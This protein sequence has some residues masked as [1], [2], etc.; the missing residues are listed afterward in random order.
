MTF[1]QAYRLTLGLNILVLIFYC[2]RFMPFCEMIGGDKYGYAVIIIL[3]FLIVLYTLTIV[4]VLNIFKNKKYNLPSKLATILLTICIILIVGLITMFWT[5]KESMINTMIF[6]MPFLL[7]DIGHLILNF[8]K[9][10]N[11]K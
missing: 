5:N 1:R 11:N 9:F 7:I 2:F 3:P 4:S 10:N 8:S 6:I